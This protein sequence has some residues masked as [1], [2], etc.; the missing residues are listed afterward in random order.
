MRGKFPSMKEE[1]LFVYL[2][3]VLSKVGNNM[4][5]IIH[6]KNKSIGTQKHIVKLV[7]PLSIYTFESAVIYVKSLL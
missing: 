1:D 6:K 7:E 5:N 2:G 3:R 4:Q